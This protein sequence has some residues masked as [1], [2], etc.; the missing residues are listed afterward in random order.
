M[1]TQYYLPRSEEQ[2]VTWLNNF[3]SVLPSV[4]NRYNIG[5]GEQNEVMS[6]A[7]YY[8]ALITFQQ[9]VSDFS[10]ALTRYKNAMQYG[11]IAG[12]MNPTFPL[13]PPINLP[14]APNYDMFGRITALVARIKGHYAY[15]E[16]DGANLGITGSVVTAARVDLHLLKP[17]LQLR[18]THNGAPEILWQSQGMTGIT[19]EVDRGEGSGWH[20]LAFDTIPNY[21]DTA[22]RP[23]AGAVWRYRAIYRLG[24]DTVGQWSD[25]VSIA[26]K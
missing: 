13:Q 9:K 10:Q 20:F 1:A 3:A 12:Q 7:L 8:A 19:I 15:N 4:A 17:H 22:D 5:V 18:L 2:R 23:A 21:T 6:A 11:V 24:D 16:I 25:E 14:A 26:V